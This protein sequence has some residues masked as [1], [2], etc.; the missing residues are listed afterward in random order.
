MMNSRVRI[1][2]CCLWT[3]FYQS[4]ISIFKFV[5]P[6]KENHVKSEELSREKDRQRKEKNFS[7]SITAHHSNTCIKI[8]GLKYL[9]FKPIALHHWSPRLTPLE[10]VLQEITQTLK[11]RHLQEVI[12]LNCK[13]LNKWLWFFLV[14]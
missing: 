6:G 12:W 14:F 9:S 2:L 1:T 7:L 10:L 8:Q 13:L 3:F 4:S 11:T 5:L